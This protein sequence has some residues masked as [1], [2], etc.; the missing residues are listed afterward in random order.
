MEG[1]QVHFV[2]MWYV[3]DFA[4]IS[5]LEFVLEKCALNNLLCFHLTKF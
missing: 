1:L 3:D 2:L 5:C 4:Y